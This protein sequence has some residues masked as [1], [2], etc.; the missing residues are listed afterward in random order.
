MSRLVHY[1]S[2]VA[3]VQTVCQ[4]F[5]FQL[6]EYVKVVLITY[7]SGGSRPEPYAEPDGDLTSGDESQAEMCEVVSKKYLIQHRLSTLES[8]ENMEW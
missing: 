5:I 1:V 3:N 2:S 4:F 6:A 7:E 8:K